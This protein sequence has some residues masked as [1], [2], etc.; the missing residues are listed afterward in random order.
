MCDGAS[1]ITSLIQIVDLP[2]VRADYDPGIPIQIEVW[3]EF[4]VLNGPANT[5]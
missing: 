4:I 2:F 1:H 5:M 3:R